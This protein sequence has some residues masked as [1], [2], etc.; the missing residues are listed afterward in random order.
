MFG[1]RIYGNIFE[2]YRK[3][4]VKY[5]YWI[6]KIFYE[7]WMYEIITIFYMIEVS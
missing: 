7:V 6:N 4:E 1:E 2:K 3:N 5:Y